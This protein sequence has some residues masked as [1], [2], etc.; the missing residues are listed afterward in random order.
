MRRMPKTMQEF[1]SVV[2]PALAFFK[3]LHSILYKNS[4]YGGT[5]FLQRTSVVAREREDTIGRSKYYGRTV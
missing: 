3:Q 2:A 4:I 1:R 5:S